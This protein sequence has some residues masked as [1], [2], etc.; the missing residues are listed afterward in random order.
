MSLEAVPDSRK[1]RAAA[2]LLDCKAAR[3]ESLSAR[4]GGRA[5]LI[6]H[7]LFWKPGMHLHPGAAMQLSIKTTLAARRKVQLKASLL[8]MKRKLA[9]TRSVELWRVNRGIQTTEWKEERR[10][11]KQSS[12]TRALF[13]ALLRQPDG[14]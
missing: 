7:R 9:N 11:A 1:N 8:G 10:Q 6:L 5:V 14:S 2:S 4:S 12:T 3:K 13:R